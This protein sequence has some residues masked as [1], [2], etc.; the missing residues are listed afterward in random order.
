M[1]CIISLGRFEGRMEIGRT[2]GQ[3]EIKL[4]ESC[5]HWRVYH[6]PEI[7]MRWITLPSTTFKISTTSN[8]GLSGKDGETYI[9]C[10]VSAVGANTH[11]FRKE[12][13]LRWMFSKRLLVIF[14]HFPNQERTCK[15]EPKI[16]SLNQEIY[17]VV[18]LEIRESAAFLF[19]ILMT[20]R[21]TWH[22]RK[23]LRCMSLACFLLF[24]E[25]TNIS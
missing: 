14:I 4:D 9:F 8:I 25:L 5:D 17:K 22:I 18:C 2:G 12:G 1:R 20:W 24:N 16:V 3:F 23:N 13:K 19:P 15:S 10:H 21:V 6:L 7:S 11:D